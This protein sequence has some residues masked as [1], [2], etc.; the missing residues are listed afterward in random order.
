MARSR[1]PICYSST[2]G[3]EFESTS[4]C[5]V[6]VESRA[7]RPRHPCRF[8]LHPGDIGI[9]GP[10]RIAGR[11][12]EEW[13]LDAAAWR[14]LGATHLLVNTRNAGLS[15]PDGHVDAIRRFME[16]ARAAAAP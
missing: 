16:S 15:F 10:I 9:D 3:L 13:V 4:P 6:P 1:S 5:S 12:Q 14:D 8:R 11:S 7:A 2:A